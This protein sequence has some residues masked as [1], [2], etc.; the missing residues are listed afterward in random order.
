MQG[1]PPGGMGMQ[2][3]P[4]G[5]MGMQGP[6][7]GGQGPPAQVAAGMPPP[8]HPQQQQQGGGPAASPAN[9]ASPA[10]ASAAAPAVA[11]GGGKS[12]WT[13]HQDKNSGKTYYYNAQSR[14]SVWTKPAELEQASAAPEPAVAA[15][16]ATA[17]AAAT[18]APAPAA[19]AAA[20]PTSGNGWKEYTAPD[21]RKYYHK[22][23][24]NTTQWTR[25]AEMDE[26]AKEEVAK[27]S[28]DAE[29]SKPN[30]D[31]ATKQVVLEEKDKEVEDTEE[32]E[33]EEEIKKEVKE[34]PKKKPRPEPIPDLPAKKYE[35]KEEAMLDFKELLDDKIFN[36]KTTWEEAIKELQGDV[37]F[38]ALKSVGEKKNVFQNFI[39][40]KQKGFVE[41]ERVRKKQAK[42]DFQNMLEEADPAIS[43]NSRFRDVQEQLGKDERFS[44][45]DSDRERADLFE[46]FVM[47]L[48]KKNKEKLREARVENVAAF[49]QLLAEI[50]ELTSKTRWS[51]VK[52]MVKEDERFLALEGDDKYRL[53]AFDEFMLGLAR[54]EALE[55][56]QLKD[57]KRALEKEQRAAFGVMLT[58]FAEK[59]LVH[60]LS[61]WRE[62]R[63]TDEPKAEARFTEMVEQSKSKA[64]DMFD[65]FVEELQAKYQKNRP[66]LKESYKAAE[67]MD[68]TTCGLE[69]FT[70]TIR[71]HESCA[72]AAQGDIDM[73]YNE[74]VA[75]AQEDLEKKERKRQRA[76]KDFKRLVKKYFDRGKLVPTA[77]FE[78]AE[79]VCGERSAWKDVAADKRQE[80]FAKLIEDLA[81]GNEEEEEGERSRSRSRKRHRR[82]RSREKEATRSS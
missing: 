35:S 42:I 73:F 72:D 44:K 63:E 49:R 70:A 3:P 66:A 6:P 18:P 81:K 29:A 22:A 14:Q 79:S 41:T 23:E 17:A 76:E 36:H 45:V 64:Q 75:L 2:G 58:E 61:V 56:E 37:R 53:E 65:D 19:A 57:K 16:P 67:K 62:W 9:A 39:A 74:L 7:P 50:P 80:L 71:A 1:P 60:G 69:V 13:E 28:P 38:K 30:G 54:N 10:I 21:G 78:D 59:R 68:I 15:V 27:P 51:E 52:L 82:S 24:S 33:K 77:S 43:H 8:G 25:P 46:D 11:G 32:K 20:K 4:A 40:K 26:V 48:E 47:E 31:D 5:S 55:R 12:V 34:P